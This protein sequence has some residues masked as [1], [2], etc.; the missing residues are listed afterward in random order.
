[1]KKQRMMG[2]DA[3]TFRQGCKAYLLN[4]RQRNLRE[5][6][7]NHYRQSYRQ[8]YKQID[9]DM[10]LGSFNVKVY[11]GYVNYLMDT[12]D[13]DV[14]INAYLRDLM[15]TLRFLMA[16]GHM[17]SFTMKSIKVDKQ[18]VSTYTD[19]ELM[20]LL[21]KP[22]IRTCRY[23]EYQCW[24]MTNLLFSTGIRQRS[25]MNLTIRD[26]DL[27]NQILHVRV[28]KNRKPLVIPLNATMCKI[29]Q[30]YFTY[31][32]ADDDSAMLFTNVFDQPL[33]RST[34]YSMLYAYNKG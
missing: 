5:G 14:T 18:A 24:V 16:E 4:C 28:T 23:V 7:I 19:A 17:R 32:K 27:D 25:L 21:R 6:T 30:E 1:M 12:L 9:P 33:V 10:P 34:C 29:L 15:T 11:E 26:V 22:D 31:R 8:F 13:N 2:A 3:M 20:L